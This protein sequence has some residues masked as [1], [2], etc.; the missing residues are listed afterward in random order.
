MTASSIFSD[1]KFRRH[2]VIAHLILKEI[3]TSIFLI[4]LH[5]QG[6]SDDLVAYL[7]SL[8]A[9]P[10]SHEVESAQAKSYVTYAISAL[11]F[12]E[13]EILTTT[14]L[15]ARNLVAAFG[16]TGLRTWEA[17]LHLGNYLCSNATSL[18][19]GKSILEL[20]A[21][22]GYVSI[23]CAKNL[24]ATHVIATD[25]SEEV[26]ASLST[27]FYLNGLQGA[28]NIEGK[29]LKWGHALIGGEHPEWNGGKKIELVLGADLT[30]DGTA[31]LALVATFADLFNLYPQVK[32]IIAAPIRNP[33]TIETFLTTCRAKNYHV[34]EIKYDILAPELQNGPFYSNKVPIQICSISRTCT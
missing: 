21:G 27:N 25:G 32:I 15:E 9:S 4:V 23:L 34:Q 26:V 29:E 18:V 19:R 10:V 6:V 2:S 33:K 7:S 31:I 3:S 14:L 16:T 20:G 1:F 17:A 8:L 22:T 11:E 30:Y 5:S 13:Q 12:K 24:G 28:S